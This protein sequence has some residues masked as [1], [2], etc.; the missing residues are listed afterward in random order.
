MAGSNAAKG[1]C[2][3]WI[4]KQVHEALSRKVAK[5]RRFL[6]SE[7]E[8]AIALGLGYESIEALEADFPVE[9][10][11]DVKEKASA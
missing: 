3:I 10:A 11:A 5:T 7:A 6:R 2:Q 8:E 1:T 4:S 9:E